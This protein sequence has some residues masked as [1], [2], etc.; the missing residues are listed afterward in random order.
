MKTKISA[1][2]MNYVQKKVDQKKKK[3]GFSE[4]LLKIQVKINKM[5]AEYNIHE[6]EYLQ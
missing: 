3:E 5:R 4:N 6:G 2:L 1:K